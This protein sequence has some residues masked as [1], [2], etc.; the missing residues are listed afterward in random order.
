MCIRDSLGTC[1]AHKLQHKWAASL[2]GAR[3][4]SDAVPLSN[5]GSSGKPMFASLNHGSCHALE[6][7]ENSK[8]RYPAISNDPEL[9]LFLFLSVSLTC[10][11]LERS[12]NVNHNNVE[13]K[14]S[15]SCVEHNPTQRLSLNAESFECHISCFELGLRIPLQLSPISLAHK[16]THTASQG[17]LLKASK[18]RRAKGMVSRHQFQ[19]EARPI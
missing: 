15:C 10:A 8:R 4:L 1:A 2:S 7:G 16:H 6:N 18:P 17:Q 3:I 19:Q 14:L 13:I 11:I 12:A 5:Q 9:Q